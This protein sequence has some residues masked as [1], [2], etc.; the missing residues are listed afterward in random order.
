ME[1]DVNEVD[2]HEFITIFSVKQHG[3]Y[4]SKKLCND[5]RNEN[6]NETMYGQFVDKENNTRWGST[7]F[8]IG[9]LGLVHDIGRI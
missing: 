5:T 4:E 6:T 3:H 9:R 1:L 2:H 7:H 8:I